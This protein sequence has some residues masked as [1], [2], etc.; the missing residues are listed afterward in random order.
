MKRYKNTKTGATVDTMCEISGEDWIL[1][2]ETVDAEKND[3]DKE[4]TAKKKTTGR[5][6]GKK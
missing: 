5:K 3:V 2:N 4:A 6:A 1:D